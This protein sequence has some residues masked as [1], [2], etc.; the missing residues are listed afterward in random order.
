LRGGRNHWSGSIAGFAHDDLVELLGGKG[1]FQHRV[2]RKIE[3]SEQPVLKCD[4]ITTA[5][6]KEVSVAVY[7]GEVVGV[8]G[9]D[10][11]GQRALLHEI[12]SPSRGS[13]SAID[14]RGKA[15]YVTG[16]RQAEGLFY[17]WGISRNIVVGALRGVSPW[18]FVRK[19]RADEKV[20]QWSARLKLANVRDDEVVGNLSGGN[21][22]RVL[23]AR[24]FASESE[25]LLFDDPM[26]GVDAGTKSDFY[27]L[28]QELREAGNCALLYTT[29]D[30][31]FLYCDRVYVMRGG[32]VQQELRDDQVSVE[33]I[34]QWS[35]VG[36]EIAAPNPL[37][38]RE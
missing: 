27:A 37:T 31:E 28:L 34:I 18:G 15:A 2:T 6:L 20:R 24:G 7:P 32:S 36:N 21:Q 13:R 12:Y 1:S 26:R 33:N 17:Q 3:R 9:L 19:V 38:D 10:G 29:E 25:L 8:A 14:L 16:D 22:Q 30:T 35:F 11:A 5:Q 4:Q 23:I